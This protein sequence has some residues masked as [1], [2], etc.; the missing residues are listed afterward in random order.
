[1]EISKKTK[2]SGKKKPRTKDNGLIK[3]YGY[4]IG[5]DNTYLYVLIPFPKSTMATIMN[6]IRLISSLKK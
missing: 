3:R 1:M 6:K 4:G 2:L 5:I